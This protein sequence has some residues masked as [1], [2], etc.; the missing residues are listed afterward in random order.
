MTDF[1]DADRQAI[2]DYFDADP[3]LVHVLDSAIKNHGHGYIERV[4]LGM[5]FDDAGL[6]PADMVHPD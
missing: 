4:L 1:S 6:I 2:D 3:L 5:G